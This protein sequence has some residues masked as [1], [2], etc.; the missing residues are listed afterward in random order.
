M[1]G[2]CKWKLE[3]FDYDGL[4][5]HSPLREGP[6]ELLATA[7]EQKAKM[8]IVRVRNN[9]GKAKLNRKWRKSSVYKAGQDKF[10]AER[11]KSQ[12]ALQNGRIAPYLDLVTLADMAHEWFLKCDS[13]KREFGMDVSHL[14]GKFNMT[15]SELDDAI[16]LAKNPEYVPEDLAV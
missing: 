14:K 6:D 3:D 8:E 10:H 16:E 12:K 15:Q 4:G 5:T 7:E 13:L 1:F 11:R 2:A 9:V